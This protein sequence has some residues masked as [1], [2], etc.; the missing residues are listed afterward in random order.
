MNDAYL[1][2]AELE[3]LGELGEGLVK[4]FRKGAKEECQVDIGR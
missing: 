2:V 1:S 3:E 4:E